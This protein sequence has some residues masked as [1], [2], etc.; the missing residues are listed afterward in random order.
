MGRNRRMNG[1]C[2]TST[3]RASTPET[4]CIGCDQEGDDQT[5]LPN[6]LRNRLDRDEVFL[7]SPELW[8]LVDNVVQNRHLTG[9]LLQQSY[10]AQDRLAFCKSVSGRNEI[11]HI[12]VP[13]KEDFRPVL[14]IT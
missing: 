3:T 11:R 6:D 8:Q 7:E 2:N 1:N 5:W 10:R 12:R 14:A 4:E 13:S 9:A